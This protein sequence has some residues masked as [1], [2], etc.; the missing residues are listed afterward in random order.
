MEQNV[1]LQATEKKQA[2][3]AGKQSLAFLIGALL[4]Y[5]L[6]Y[7][8]V[9][10]VL[11]YEA[12]HRS[13]G[14]MYIFYAGYLLFTLLFIAS[15]EL[16]RYFG[17]PKRKSTE[18]A[19]A[20]RVAAAGRKTPA[21]LAG[22]LRFEGWFWAG[23][24]LLQ[25]IALT[26]YSPHAGP[27]GI[28]QTLL[29]HLTA[30]Y[31]VLQRTDMLA[32]GRT[33]CLIGLDLLTGFLAI[34]CLNVMLR[35][36]SVIRGIVSLKGPKKHRFSWVVL[37]SVLAA[38]VVVMIAWTQLSAAD[39][40]F[41]RLGSRL[42]GWIEDVLE[43]FSDE[44]VLK[45]ILSVPVGCFLFALTG[46]AVRR[47]RALMTSE[48]FARET[49]GFRRVPAVSAV[50][51]IGALT[52][53]YALFFGL[54]AMEFV[55]ALG[56][57]AAGTV[58]SAPTASHFA[59]QGFWELFRILF[60]NMLVLGAFS[61]LMDTKNGRER[62]PLRRGALRVL[63]SVFAASGAAFAVLDLVKLGVYIHRYGYTPKRVLAG[64]FLCMLFLCAVIFVLRIFIS[65]RAV[66]LAVFLMA[67]GFTLFSLLPLESMI[68][69]AN[70]ARY[71]AGV[72]RGVDIDVLRECRYPDW[73]KYRDMDTA[74][75]PY[76]DSY[77][78]YE[79]Y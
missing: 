66:P 17:S 65:F 58:I 49:A 62:N 69:G 12:N 38:A 47:E 46:G 37:V 73:E 16:L 52:T 79:D 31:Y 15:V 25:A 3:G 60:L 33:G 26:V 61:F 63:T 24:L 22:G 29:W 5:P 4:S 23:I 64:W 35:L 14:T 48:E 78:S 21:V 41:A 75:D 43:S 71:E 11:L 28:W 9:D 10:A 57:S 51:V 40:N 59:V 19:G 70:I 74:G 42:S 44:F 27:I 76:D 30:V 53:V 6:A 68:T 45:F 2:T 34:P 20:V 32:A 36:M 7:I 1:R 77:D 72:D 50:I 55:S 8:Y 56:G 13:S 39:D 54:Q 67:A 18:R